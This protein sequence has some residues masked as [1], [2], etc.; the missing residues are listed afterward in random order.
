MTKRIS[1]RR[2]YR[3][4]T[5]HQFIK[6]VELGPWS[7]YSLLNDPKHLC[8]VLARYKFVSKMF[9]G[10]DQ[11][12]E[13]GCGDAFGS[14][15]VAQHVGRLLAIEPDARH[16]EGNVQRLA[17]IKNLKFR[18][19]EIQELKWNKKYF[20]GVYS[21]DVIEHLDKQL[22]EPFIGS[23]AKIL[24]KNGVC[25]VGTPN[26]TANAYASARSKVQHINLHSHQTLKNLMEKFFQRVFLFGM[27]DEVVHTGYAPMCHYIFAMGTGVK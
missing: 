17:A 5:D 24:K 13:V 10:F 12:L 25:I 18:Q 4:G 7:T 22:N 21:I 14:P 11:A 6:S 19:G 1:Q 20:D 27:N 8:F 16:I 3:L 23:Q 26:K 9:D 15:I 2:A